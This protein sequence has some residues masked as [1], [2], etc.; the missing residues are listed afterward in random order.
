M[1]R[2]HLALLWGTHVVIPD[3]RAGRVREAILAPRSSRIS[4]VVLRRGLRGIATLPLNRV[5][6]EADGTLVLPR[7]QKMSGDAQ[8]RRG[9]IHFSP[10]NVVHCGDASSLPLRGFLLDSGDNAVTSLLAG[11]RGNPKVIAIDKV[12][13]LGSGSPSATDIQ[14]LDLPTYRTAYEAQLRAEGALRNADP[15]GGAS[16]QAVQ[17]EVR[18][19]TAYLTGNV[20]LPVQKADAERAVRRASGVIDVQSDIATDQDIQIAIAEAIARAGL[21]R[22]G[23]VLVKSSLGRVTLTGSLASNERVQ[24]AASLAGA[25]D[26]VHEVA[27]GIGIAEPPPAVEPPPE[28]EEEGEGQE[29]EE[30]PAKEEEA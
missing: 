7:D 22:S 3:G 29:N 17:V 30:E 27:T 12:K 20:R 19:G 15:T 2:K 21:T 1:E 25:T 26:G 23:T 10:R 5:T 16:Y 9:S 8:P 6:Q 18:D 4:H 11:P 13:N 14:M 24:H 28:L